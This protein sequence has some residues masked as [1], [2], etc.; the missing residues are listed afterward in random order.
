MDLPTIERKNKHFLVFQ[1]YFS[2]W[3]LVYPVSNQ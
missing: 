2:K 3:P 1:D